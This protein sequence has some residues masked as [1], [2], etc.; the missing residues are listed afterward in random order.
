MALDVNGDGI[1]SPMEWRIDWSLGEPIWENN[2]YYHYDLDN[3]TVTTYGKFDDNVIMEF[4]EL[5]FKHVI[6]E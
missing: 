3:K 5:G 2:I 6:K 4:T 1:I